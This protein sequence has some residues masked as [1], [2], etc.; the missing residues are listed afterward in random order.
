MRKTFKWMG[1]VLLGVVGLVVVAITVAFV[2]L[3]TDWGRDR[4]RRQV[5]ASLQNTFTGGATIGRLEGSPF[6]DL[7]LREV[8]INGPDLKP[9]ITIASLRIHL[10]LA[11]LLSHDVKLGK[12]IAE[13][14]DVLIKREA[15]GELMFKHLTKPGPS[16]AWNVNLAQVE[17]H[18]GHVMFDTGKEPIDLDGIQLDARGD[19]PHGGPISFSSVLQ[20]RWRQKAVPVTAT[21]ALRIDDERVAIHAAVVQVGDVSV[22]VAGGQIPKG[23]ARAFSGSV[24][25]IA[26]AEQVAA[27]VPGIQLPADLALAIEA[28]PEGSVT[29]LAIAGTVG[30]APIR[31]FAR[32]DLVATSGSGFVFGDGLD[33]AR[34]SKDRVTGIGGAFAAFEIVAGSQDA[35]PTAHAMITTWGEVDDMPHADA[36]IALDTDGDRIRVVV[37]A[38]GVTGFRAA[39]GAELHRHGRS[40]TLDRSVALVSTRDAAL[41]TGGKA[42]VHGVLSANLTASGALMPQPDLAIAGHV[43]GGHLRLND[44]SVASLHFRMDANHLP[45][46]PIGSA[47]V[48]VVDLVRQDV[49][50]SKLTLAAGNR[51]DGKVQVSLRSNPKRAPT[52]VDLDALVTPGDT[53]AV[54]LQRHI[55]RAAGGDLWTGTTGHLVIAKDKIELTDLRSSSADGKLALEGSYVRAGAH[56]GDLDAKASGGLELSNVST[57]YRGRIDANV[58]VQRRAGKLSGVIVGKAR[59]L[60]SDESLVTLDVDGKI[61]ARAG[62]LVANV[63]ASSARVGSAVIALDVAAPQDIT[64]VAQWRGLGRE[65]IR[66]ADLKLEGIDI[67]AVADLADID[68][69]TMRGKIDGEI[70]ITKTTLGGLIQA[71]GIHTAQMKDAGAIDAEIQIAQNPKDDDEIMTTINTAFEG[72]GRIQAEARFYTPEHLFDPVAWKAQGIDAF[73]GGSVRTD[74]IPFEPGTL[75]RFGIATNLRGNVAFQANLARGLR[76][77]TV[78]LDAHDLRGGPLAE[79]IAVH[80]DAEIDATSTHGMMFVR[81]NDNKVTL[82]H[83]RLNTPITLAELR[84]NPKALGDAALRGSILIP[85]VPATALLHTL[86]TEQVS[87]GTI[88]GSIE[89]GGTI[90]RPTATAALV[91]RDVT[92]PPGLR[93]R[94]V[95]VMKELKIDASWDGG[96]GKVAIKGIESAGGTLNIAGDARL[97]A[98]KDATIRFQASRLDLAPLVAF[99]PGPAG[100]LGG[101]LDADLTARGIDPR[102]ADI[103]GTLAVR[104]GRL[105]IAPQVGTLFHGDLKVEIENHTIALKLKGNLG[106]GDVELTANAPLDG[107]SPKGGKATLKLTKVKL[108]G[109]TEP[110]ITAMITADLARVD[111][112]WKANIEVTKAVVT[113]PDEKGTKLAPA[114]AP[115]DLVYGGQARTTA[116]PTQVAENGQDPHRT[117]QEDNPAAI[118]EVVIK[119]A[120]VESKELRGLVNG[121][122]EIELGSELTINGDLGLNRGDLDLFDRR[123]QIE[124]AI[125]HFD[126]ATDP[127][128]DVRI[129]YD[130]PDVETVTEIHGRMS[131][132]QLQMMSNPGIYSQAELLGFLLGGEP[133][134]D[135]RNAPS[136]S[137]KVTGAGA[138]IVANQIGKYF[139]KSLPVNI[140]VM[141]YEASSATSSSAVTVGSW[142]SRT[143]FVAYRQHLAAR[144]DEN[145]GEADVEYWLRRRL[146]L[147]GVIG[148]R[149]KE[150]IDLLWRRRW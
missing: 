41:A 116:T 56:A 87:G 120:Y 143:L 5:E 3:H 140:D 134:G 43:D 74:R 46:H 44:A 51:P 76:G 101:Q 121:K 81:T 144:P 108:I 105:P 126:G 85:Q 91:A 119:D 26:P 54:D 23:D 114:G 70:K 125:V 4:I 32:A 136:A 36:V 48:E 29:Q 65:A 11:P 20:G 6:T 80:F 13:D 94:S 14:V 96:G 111:E 61:D 131:N 128:L 21:A 67:A 24:A 73:H 66:T 139:K 82:L 113:V 22:A 88:D 147:E 112:Q 71:R 40:L 129:T 75:E 77:S 138:S 58:E 57:S 78:T 79:P 95:Q 15:N 104:D 132:P 30:G 45:S 33:L 35:L 89:L 34:L 12:V 19:L 110:V 60:S 133:G 31:G 150:G 90:G 146:V 39:V 130:F 141:R 62:H 102:T 107:V 42:L 53:I 68:Q 38:T 148:D 59:N 10:A 83:L 55:V 118:A 9:A 18:R 135:P 98:L 117:M 145:S 49:E 37:G 63:N 123:Y 103:A 99:M 93:G 124:R 100:G 122:L 69:Q 106:K 127:L 27:L 149:G 142:I 92:V 115:N 1:R 8:V 64:K 50:I 17:L 25:L 84:A 28:R 47:R 86:G 52:R 16:S 2:I 109:T 137:D 72:I 97:D 7:I